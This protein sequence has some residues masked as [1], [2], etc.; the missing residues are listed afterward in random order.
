MVQVDMTGFYFLGSNLQKLRQLR[1]TK[2]INEKLEILASVEYWL[3]TF[4]DRSILKLENSQRIARRLLEHVRA[5]VGA[6]NLDTGLV[7]RGI[8]DI[9]E[10]TL[11]D[12]E[13]AF[14]AEFKHLLIFYVPQE[15]I[16]SVSKLMYEAESHLSQQ[17]QDKLDQKTR[18]DIRLAGTCLAMG[19]ILGGTLTLPVGQGSLLDLF[20]A[21]GFHSVRAVEAAARKYHMMITG[22]SVPSEEPLGPVIN[23]LRQQLKLEDGKD[24]SDSRLGLTISLLVRIKNI[25]RNPIT[26]PEMTLN[27]DTAKQVFDLTATV[28]STIEEDLQHRPTNVG[29]PGKVGNKPN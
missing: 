16:Y 18:Q 20:T 1:S 26:H 9:L 10:A 28:I 23:G 11:N 22:Q 13:A 21:S 3:S 24:A 14:A 8:P 12:L 7:E 15:G 27:R 17:A 29:T 4:L 25:Y 2:G 5:A 19:S 6:I